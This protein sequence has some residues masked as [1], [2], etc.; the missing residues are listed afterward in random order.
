MDPFIK[1]RDD[2]NTRIQQL[3]STNNVFRV[4]LNHKDELWDA[5]LNSFAP[6]HNPLYETKTE[7]DCNCCKSFIRNIGTLISINEKYEY[8]TIWDIQVD[9]IYKASVK[10]MKDIVLNRPIKNV[11][12]NKEHKLGNK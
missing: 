12:L 5:Y 3:L 8:E 9:P 4:E 1:F 6:E 7:H 2:V 11:Y 10:A